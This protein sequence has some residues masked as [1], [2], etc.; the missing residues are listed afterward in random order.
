M[1]WAI[2]LIISV[3]TLKLYDLY[4]KLNLLEIATLSTKTYA[5][6]F[7]SLSMLYLC[8][9]FSDFMFAYHPM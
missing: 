4:I 3:T 7:F 9:V 8:T 6:L 1:F 5:I 2:N